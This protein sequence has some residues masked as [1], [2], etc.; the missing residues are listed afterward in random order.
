MFF[1]GLLYTKQNSFDPYNFAIV[2]W[3][4]TDESTTI[5]DA[6]CFNEIEVRHIKK[7]FD[8]RH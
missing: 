5:N 3:L 4:F 1:L 2:L 6:V 8:W 7:F